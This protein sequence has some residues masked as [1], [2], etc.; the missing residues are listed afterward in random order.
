[1]Q[2][3]RHRINLQHGLQAHANRFEQL[4]RVGDGHQLADEASQIKQTRG[5]D[6]E[7]GRSGETARTQR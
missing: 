7:W 2:P 3:Q 1:M 5:R 6:F 4:I